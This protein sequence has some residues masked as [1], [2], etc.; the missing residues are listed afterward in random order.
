[1]RTVTCPRCGTE[2]PAG[3]KF[4]A[5]CGTR[6]TAPSSPPPVEER[7]L[8]TMLFA[9]LAGSTMLGESLDP[10]A[11]YSLTQR[12]HHRL[13]RIV[14]RYEGH[15][16][17]HLGDG[18]LVLFGA[19][20]AHENDAERA[21]LA[22]L[23]MQEEIGR[24]NAEE[25]DPPLGMRIGITTGEVVAGRIT[26]I[27]DVI[28]DAPNVAARLQGIAEIGM[29]LVGEEAMRLARRRIQFGDRRQLTLKGKRAPV[30]C[31]VALGVRGQMGERWEGT[32]AAAASTAPA[33][34]EERRLVTALFCDLVGFTPLSEQLDPE[35]LREIQAA[36]F[37]AMSQQIERYG[38]IVEKYAGDAVLALFGVPTA[39]EDDPERAVLCA[40]GMQHAIRP[41]AEDVRRRCGVEVAMRVG[42]N[43]GDVVSGSWDASGLQQAAVSGDA[44]NTAARLQAAAEPGGVLVGEETMRLARRRI[45]FGER[46]PLTLKGK[47][48]PVGTYAAL[49]MR[50]QLGERWDSGEAGGG[51]PTPL[52]GRAQELAVIAVGWARAQTGDGR[53]L[54]IVGEPGVGK[55]R[56]VAEAVD[57]IAMDG[58]VRLLRGRCLS[59]GQSVSLWLIADLLR[60]VCLVPED[61]GVEVVRERVAEAMEAILADSDTTDRAI[62]RDVLGEVLGLPAG[63][64]LVAAAGPQARRSA[65]VRILSLVVRALAAREPVLVVLEDLHWL[66]T[67]SQ[68]VLEAILRDVEGRHILVL[69]TQRPGWPA[70]WMEWGESDQVILPALDAEDASSLA[71]AVLGDLLLS[72]ELEGHLRKRAEGNPFFV[73]E[74]LHYLQETGA[75]ETEGG[76]ARLRAGV[77]EKLPATL[78]EVLLARLDRLASQVKSVAQVGSVIGRSFAVRLLSRVMEREEA[79]LDEPL[80]ALQQAEITYRDVEGEL[81]HVFRHVLLRDA[82]YSMLVR[83][84]Q[85]RLHLAVGRAIAQLYPT[86]EYVELI[87][88]HYARTEEDE[89]A[90]PWLEKAGDRAMNTYANDAAIEH[91]RGALERLERSGGE[92]VR[93]AGIEVKLGRLLNRASRQEEAQAVA[94][95]AI[96]R[97]REAGDRERAAEATALLGNVLGNR[98]ELAEARRTLEAAA[99][100][101]GSSPSQVSVELQIDLAGVCQFQGRYREMLE[102]VERAGEI[103]RA[104]GEKK[105]QAR[106]GAVRGSALIL[107][108]RVEEAREALERA[109]PSLEAAGDLPW[110]SFA[111]GCLGENRRVVGGLTEA[112]QLNERSLELGVRTGYVAEEMGS[113]LNLVEILLAT[114]E[115]G[116]AREHVARAEEIERT[117]GTDA[118]AACI[119]PLG[120][121]TLAMREGDW[122]EAAEQLERAT[123]LAARSYR[124]VLEEAQ[125]VLGELEIVKEKPREA[126]DRLSGLVEE[127]E[128]DLPL[129][130]PAF[131]WAHLALGDAEHALEL[132]ERAER[133]GRE[134]GVLLYL[135]EALRI[136]GMALIRLERVTEARMVL[137]EGR[138]QAGTM[139]NP[140]TEAR[141]LVELGRLDRQEGKGDRAREQ[142]EEALVTF[143]RLRARKDVER[144]ELELVELRHSEEPGRN[145][146]YS[147]RVEPPPAGE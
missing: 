114:G 105:L 77:A 69:A 55:S 121:G 126:T 42:V 117:R 63:D 81:Q 122:E 134:R 32:N 3:A 12:V 47:R 127:E 79:L 124:G 75:L 111:I 106:V 71:R 66:D 8:V 90:A 120:L 20:V 9:D 72:S 140:Y 38:G 142:L 65:L 102:A 56:L 76:E 139:P 136:K 83:R 85:R 24:L 59:Y 89:E 144:T 91:Y 101:A 73:E 112:L 39:H 30:A 52:I 37:S 145:S 129:L 143:R 53:I 48:E 58:D 135:P 45:R 4:C 34:A 17:R 23:A 128:A 31:Y 115:W 64:S 103:A 35:D 109:I 2:S 84:R 28:G 19:P 40:L 67:A 98:G 70:P 80:S 25:R 41:V 49:G 95:Q 137:T 125:A 29:V 108:G 131:A 44:V 13:E 88:Y 61:A 7:R 78:A 110:L 62:A 54:T 60:A 138:E 141:I 133:E 96:G 82:A 15:V 10:D 94:E 16:A 99:E 57:R 119:L 116:R 5:E 147:T 68:E 93:R 18:L 118:W 36:Y 46:Q 113:H 132:A 22:A 27:Y 92:G 6:L 74:L 146:A 97:Y 43:T 33:P 86:D 130:L 123:E 51:Y 11:L 21:V 104:I 87:A 50:A 14:H 1:M 26:G 100:L 107:L